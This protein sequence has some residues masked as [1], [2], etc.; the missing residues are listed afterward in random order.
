VPA[1][2]IHLDSAAAGA[3]MI[4]LAEAGAVRLLAI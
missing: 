1:E 4:E 2:R 3:G